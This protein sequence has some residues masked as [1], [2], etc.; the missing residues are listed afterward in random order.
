V[1][2]Q[3]AGELWDAKAFFEVRHVM[4]SLVGIGR[5]LTPA[6]PVPS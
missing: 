1:D 4:R 2:A 3:L 6:F 5:A